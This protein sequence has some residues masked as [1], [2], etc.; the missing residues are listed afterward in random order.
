[1]IGRKSVQLRWSERG[2]VGYLSLPDHPKKTVAG[3]VKR[4][5]DLRELDPS[6]GGPQIILDLDDQDRLIG[7]EVLR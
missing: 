3:C 7:I 2:G 6:I 1:M 4:S 5:I